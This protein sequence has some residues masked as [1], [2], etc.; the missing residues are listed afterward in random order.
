[1]SYHTLL[2]AQA[3]S[4]SLHKPEAVLECKNIDRHGPNRVIS[5]RVFDILAIVTTIEN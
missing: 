3:R 1:M 2:I 5:L 4:V